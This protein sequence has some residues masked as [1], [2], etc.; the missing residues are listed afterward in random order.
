MSECAQAQKRNNLT[1]LSKT[2]YEST[3][4]KAGDLEEDIVIVTIENEG[5]ENLPQTG[6]TRCVRFK[7]Y[8][9]SLPLNKTNTKALVDLLGDETDDW[10]GKKVKLVKSMAQNPDTGKMQNVIRIGEIT[11]KKSK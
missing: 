10:I 1:K 9:K 8:E 11:Q 4:L 6:P 7:E 3:L 2:E 5:M